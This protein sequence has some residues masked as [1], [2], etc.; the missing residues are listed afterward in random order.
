MPS[1]SDINHKINIER[2]CDASTLL[3]HPL[4][5]DFRYNTRKLENSIQLPLYRAKLSFEDVNPFNNEKQ[6]MRELLTK[7]KGLSNKATSF[8]EHITWNELYYFFTLLHNQFKFDDFLISPHVDHIKN[9]N[10]LSRY[11]KL[12]VLSIMKFITSQ[13]NLFCGAAA[14]PAQLDAIENLS[15]SKASQIAGQ[16]L[17]TVSNSDTSSVISFLPNKL[18]SFFV[19]NRFTSCL[20]INFN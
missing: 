8:F 7:K 1:F 20:T 9:Q 3:H 19:T 14:E 4:F 12:S 13:I 16:N 10:Q 15:L 18:S 6:N 5:K 17:D 2:R 11:F